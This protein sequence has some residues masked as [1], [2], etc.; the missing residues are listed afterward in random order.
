MKSCREKPF[1][2]I[3]TDTPITNQELSKINSNV[4]HLFF[5]TEQNETPLSN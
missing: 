2:D 3:D 5:N 4:F 1:L